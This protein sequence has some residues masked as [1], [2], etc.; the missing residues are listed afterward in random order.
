MPTTKETTQEADKP[1]EDFEGRAFGVLA[2]AQMSLRASSDGARAHARKV[3]SGLS[4]GGASLPSDRD[5][6]CGHTA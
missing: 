5:P 6:Q 2:L 3:L 1:L 4:S